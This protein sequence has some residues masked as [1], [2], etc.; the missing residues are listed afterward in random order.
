[1]A[2]SVN[3][4]G[5]PLEEFTDKVPPGWTPGLDRYPFKE[6][7][8]R[9]RNWVA[10]TEVAT[11]KQGLLVHGRLK[12]E[13][14]RLGQKLKITKQ[15]GDVITGHLALSFPGEVAVTDPQTGAV[16]QAEV[17]NGLH[18]LVTM[19]QGLYEAHKQ[20]ASTIALDAFFDHKKT[21]PYFNTSLSSS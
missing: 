9:L 19:L 16:V 20:D 14:W 7:V 2:S 6:Y 13:P 18:H 3:P 11:A 5:L 15:N 10:L 12:G 8:D 4:G 21:R 1:M 17:Q